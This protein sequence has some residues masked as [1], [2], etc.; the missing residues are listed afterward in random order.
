MHNQQLKC[1]NWFARKKLLSVK[2]AILKA[3]E[4]VVA[5]FCMHWWRAGCVNPLN[6]T[7]RATVWL[8]DYV[9]KI[10][11]ELVAPDSL[12]TLSP[13][14]LMASFPTPSDGEAYS[15]LTVDLSKM[16]V[17]DMAYRLTTKQ[18]VRSTEFTD[19]QSVLME[20]FKASSTSEQLYY[21]L[22]LL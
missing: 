4:H 17:F 7:C 1:V 12:P 5:M 10:S 3:V 6:A 19:F 18:E 16:L 13:A 9:V 14:T 21:I 20:S 2:F 11:G 8:V 15:V 22:I